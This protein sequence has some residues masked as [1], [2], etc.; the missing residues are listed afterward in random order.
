MLKSP[1]IS[2]FEVDDE[3]MNSTR[4][5]HSRIN[6]L[7]IRTRGLKITGTPPPQGYASAFACTLALIH[8]DKQRTR[9]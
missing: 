8:C 3:M 1:S 6:V 2:N 4:E 7:K 9:A 5:E